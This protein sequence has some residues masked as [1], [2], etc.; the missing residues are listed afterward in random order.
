MATEIGISSVPTFL[1]DQK[2]AVVGAQPVE[3]FRNALAQ[4]WEER[5][6]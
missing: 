2:Y 1:L 5:G 6:I 3:V 4:V